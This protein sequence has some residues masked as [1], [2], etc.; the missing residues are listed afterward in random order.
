MNKNFK[1]TKEQSDFQKLLLDLPKTE[2]HLHLEGIASVNTIW[3]LMNKNKIAHPDIN[4]KEDLESKFDIANLDE[5][6]DLFINI[7]Q[8]SFTEEEDIKLLIDDA[9]NYLEENNIVYAEIFFAP[10]KFLAMGFDF[11]KIIKILEDG[12]AEI[13]KKYNREIKFLIDVSR[14]FGPDNAMKN[15]DLTIKYKSPCILGIGLGGAE[16]K[17][18]AKDYKDVFEKA[19]KTGFHVVAHAG[20][21]T[22]P[23]SVWDTLKYLKAERIGHGISS[24]YDEKLM[25]TL[26]EK[27]TALEICPTSNLFTKKYVHK[28]E[29]HPVREFFNKKMNV[30][31]NT[32]DP[33]LFSINLIEEYMNLL[34]HNIFTEKEI[35][36]LIKNNIYS[37]FL[38]EKRK[39]EIWNKCLALIT[40]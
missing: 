16:S 27:Q 17:G 22:G 36:E 4:S 20:E 29:E 2:I 8:S 37:T 26:A 19:S 11:E 34:V 25:Q 9:A 40:D 32:D 30:T 12:A 21:D 18:P 15:L 10:S 28:I 24:V 23:E 5:F 35:I 38:P 3:S 33:T 13:Q 7:I 6:I 14:S 31:I 1:L 39:D